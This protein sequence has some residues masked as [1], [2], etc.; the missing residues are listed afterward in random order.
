MLSFSSSRRNWDYPTPSPAGEC[1]P[2][3]L[4]RGEGHT[5]WREEGVGESQ[6]RRGD[7]H[8]GT[9]YIYVLCAITHG[10]WALI[11]EIGGKRE[12]IGLVGSV[13]A[14]YSSSLGSKPDI[15]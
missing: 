15:Y 14:C 5:R 10:I 8:L 1:A 7:L 13:P 6:F 2:L 12:M 4:V 3:P 11:R 9:L